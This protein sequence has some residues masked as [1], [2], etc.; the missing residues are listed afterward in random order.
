MVEPANRASA[1][2]A[3]A[4]SGGAWLDAACRG[5]D[6]QTRWPAPEPCRLHDE[7]PSEQHCRTL[8]VTRAELVRMRDQLN[9][10]RNAQLVAIRT[11]AEV[12]DTFENLN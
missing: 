12:M 5:L 4:A 7:T 10:A 2:S 1:S 11:L 3:A 8:H 6:R 9:Q